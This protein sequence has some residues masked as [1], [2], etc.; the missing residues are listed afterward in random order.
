MTRGINCSSARTLVLLECHHVTSYVE[1]KI[2]VTCYIYTLQLLTY[3]LTS[4][5]FRKP[6]CV[7][8]SLIDC[9]QFIIKIFPSLPSARETQM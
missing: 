7:G 1:K 6:N 3:L 8:E 5:L 4:L 2:N 9:V